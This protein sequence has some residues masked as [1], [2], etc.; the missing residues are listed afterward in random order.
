MGKLAEWERIRRIGSGGQ[1]DVHLVRN[2]KRVADRTLYL[3]RIRQ[4]AGGCTLEGAAE[5]ADATWN[6]SRPEESSELGALKLFSIPA[7][8]AEKNEAVQRLKNEISALQ[9]GLS[10]MPKLL[11]FNE[12]ECWIVTEFFP[13]G[14]LEKQPFRYRGKV[15]E[16]LKSFRSVVQTVAELHRQ[17][18]VHRDIKPPN[19]FV[20]EDAELVL[21]DFG[22][23][24]LPNAP[25][26]VTMTGERVGPRDYMPPWS[27][28]GMRHDN[29]KPRDDVY[30]LGKLL[31]SMVAGKSVLPREYHRHPEYELDLTRIFP[32]DPQM[33][34]INAILDK[35]IV[36]RPDQ[37]LPGA[38][39]LLP[40]IDDT[41]RIALR[42]GQMTRDDIPKPCGICGK[43]FYR[44]VT[45]RENPQNRTVGLRFWVIGAGDTS[46]LPVR[47]LACNYCGHT[48]TQD[49]GIP[50]PHH[51]D[52]NDA[53]SQR[54]K[55][56]A[57]W[58]RSRVE[59]IRGATAAR[60]P[61]RRAGP[62]SLVRWTSPPARQRKK[63]VSAQPTPL[64]DLP[65][66]AAVFPRRIA[67]AAGHIPL[68]ARDSDETNR[69]GNTLHE[70]SLAASPW[71]S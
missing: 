13:K 39:E 43:G 65:C 31:W 50:G 1:S 28:L 5:L 47:P 35:C 8:G 60:C 53:K 71:C 46:T 51:R 67:I 61:G 19:I 55:F 57:R 24:Y 41:L 2:S 66:R 38:Q 54:Y 18:Y 6:Y 48:P 23:V 42:G 27:N 68:C 69:A 30:M 45:L 9:I 21:G 17:G 36:E 7:E 62:G 14:S 26:K 40:A 3:T 44:D 16:A 11:D 25:E 10:R 33:H 56:N 32:D 22:I 12:E 49:A 29:V 4:H 52:A 63:R 58:F 15:I 37:C 34:L 70:P 20:A 59:P 64:P